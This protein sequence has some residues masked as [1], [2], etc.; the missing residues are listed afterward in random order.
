MTIRTIAA[1]LIK[2]L[3]IRYALWSVVSLLSTVGLLFARTG[4]PADMARYTWWVSLAGS[5]GGI[6]AA[7][8]LVAFGDRV[9][10]LFFGEQALPPLNVSAPDLLW[11]GICLVG[12]AIAVSAV[13]SL[14]HAAATALWYAGADRQGQFTS[15]MRDRWSYTI[16]GGLSLVCGGLLVWFARPLAAWLSPGQR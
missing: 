10:G 14:V 7:A 4:G 12:V 16:D 3:G 15:V 1:L 6:V 11:I 9:A 2:L 8:L 5:L 13:P